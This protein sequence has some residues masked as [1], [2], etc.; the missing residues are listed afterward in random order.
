MTRA[1]L[2]YILCMPIHREWLSAR[3]YLTRA[4]RYHAKAIASGVDVSGAEYKLNKAI[5]RHDAALKAVMTLQELSLNGWSL[6]SE[7]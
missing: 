5:E 4:K 7:A 2:N 1:E 6:D 3:A